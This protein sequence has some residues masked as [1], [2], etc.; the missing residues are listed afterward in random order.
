MRTGLQHYIRHDDHERIKL[1]LKGLSPVQY[2][3]QPHPAQ[4]ATVQLCGFSSYAARQDFS[5]S[6]S[7]ITPRYSGS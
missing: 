6:S 7:T 1:K 4:P 3:T 2:R 5:F